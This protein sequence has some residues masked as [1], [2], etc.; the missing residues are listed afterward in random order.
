MNNRSSM[1]RLLLFF[2]FGCW[3]TLASVQAQVVSKT[4]EEKPLKTVL[5]EIEKQSGLSII[6][7]VKEVDE[8]KLVSGNF[9]NA[10]V[11]DVL[12]KILDPS[13]DVQLQNKMIVIKKKNQTS[14]KGKKNLGERNRN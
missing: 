3:G 13:L 9:K 8:N 10:Q 2:A 5:K 6:Y 1:R 12:K 7:N 4:F 14:F 11:L